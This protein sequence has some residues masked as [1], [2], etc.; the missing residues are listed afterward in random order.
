M[1]TNKII[2]KF[3]AASIVGVMTAAS[4]SAFA[5]GTSGVRA[6]AN[7]DVTTTGR[8]LIT[9]GANWNNPDNCGRTDVAIVLENNPSV[10]TF[11]AVALTAIA[12]G[13]SVQAFFNGCSDRPFGAGAQSIP[14][15]QNFS[16]Q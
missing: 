16:I 5:A 8:A 7:V 12:S 15:I 6:V 11:Q 10:K 13:L 2:N 9:P 4:S 3:I 14:I 1:K